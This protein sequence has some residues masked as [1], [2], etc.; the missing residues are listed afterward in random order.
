MKK[1][2]LHLCADIGSDSRYFDLD[3][4]FEVIK[5]GADIGVEN[6]HYSGEV[7]GVIANPV[8]TE[9]SNV[10]QHRPEVKDGLWLLKECQRVI[11]EVKPKWWVIENP[12]NGSMRDYLGKPSYVY[13]PWQY[14]SPWTKRTALWVGGDFK[15]PKPIYEK[16]EDV[17]NKLDLWCRKG[18]KPS[19]VWWHKSA[20]EHI[21]EFD[22]AVDM[23]DSDMALRSMCSQKFAKEL[24]KSN[25]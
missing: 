11:E 17:P 21:P 14:G 23:I 10:N 3:P 2:I 18:R 16:W 25:R 12:A 24:W 9:F 19:I 4:D 8:C 5:V 20:A 1:V 15:M 22:W 7:H 6:F 13:Q